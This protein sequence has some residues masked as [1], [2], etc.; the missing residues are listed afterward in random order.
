MLVITF[1]EMHA[2]PKS[3]TDGGKPKEGIREPCG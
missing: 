1:E 3:K 2:T